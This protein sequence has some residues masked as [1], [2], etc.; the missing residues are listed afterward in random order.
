MSEPANG[1]LLRR[2]VFKLYPNRAQAERLEELRRL[3]CQLYNACLQQRIEAYQ[4]CGVTLTYFDQST[5]NK[6]HDG[7]ALD[8]GLPEVKRLE[9]WREVSAD[10]MGVTA[11]RVDRA[12]KAFFAR[13]RKGAGAASGFPRFQRSDAYPGFGFKKH[14][15]G[16]RYDDVRKRCYLKSVPGEVKVRGRYPAMPLKAPRSCDLTFRAGHWWLSIVVEMAPRRAAGAQDCEVRFDLIDEFAVVR[17]ANG[18]CAA[19]RADRSP[20]DSGPDAESPLKLLS[21]QDEVIAGITKSSADA[22]V[23]PPDLRGD[24]RDL[25]ERG[26]GL[27]PAVPPDLS[28]DSR[29]SGVPGARPSLAVAPDLRGD[30]RDDMGSAVVVAPDLRDDNRCQGSDRQ[31]AMARCK[32]GSNRYRKRRLKKARAEAKV[33]RQRREALH[34]WTTSLIRAAASLTV[35]APD[36]KAATKSGKGDSRSWGAAVRIKAEINRHILTMAPG[37]AIQFLIYKAE[38][39]GIRCDVQEDKAAKVAVGGDLVTS[40]KL[41]RRAQ[42]KLKKEVS[43]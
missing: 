7:R 34:R 27:A 23:V 30:N 18:G 35:I 21:P 6:R 43:A 3:H 32:R 4:R 41:L 31:R 20:S 24:S 37:I 33:A 39:S 36:L 2:Y 26:K 17:A 1:V 15:S 28:G 29:R 10:S 19:A 14:G 9:E 40:A 12:F 22:P 13:A 8:D 38:E 16:W 42:R 5:R 25:I 11:Q